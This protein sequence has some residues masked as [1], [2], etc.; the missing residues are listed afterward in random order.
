MPPCL[1]LILQAKLVQHYRLCLQ[2]ERFNSDGPP[3]RPAL[4]LVYDK[5]L[6]RGSG[7]VMHQS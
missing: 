7:G 4:G 2:S 5:K 6:A 3:E 1:I